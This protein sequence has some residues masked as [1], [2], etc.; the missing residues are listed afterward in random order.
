MFQSS[1]HRGALIE[2]VSQYKLLGV[3]VSDDL[4]WNAHCEYIYMTKLPN[5]ST[6]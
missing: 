5:A 3:I 4:S 2:R 1:T 6:G